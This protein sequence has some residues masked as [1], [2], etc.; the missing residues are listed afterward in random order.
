MFIPLKL[1]PK[2]VCKEVAWVLWKNTLK[3]LFRSLV[4]MKAALV[5]PSITAGCLK[6]LIIFLIVLKSCC[7]ALLAAALEKLEVFAGLKTF[8][9]CLS[10]TGL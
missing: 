7:K 5:V 2:A 3:C 4:A 8:F 6:A 1:P 9:E 10:P